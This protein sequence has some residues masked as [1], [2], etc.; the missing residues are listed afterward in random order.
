MKEYDFSINWSVKIKEAFVNSL[1][2]TSQK[3]GLTFLWINDENVRDVI[4]KLE[5][6]ELK[7]KFLLDTQATYNKEGDPY[8]R[9]C[10]AVKDVGGVVINDPDRARLATDKSVMHYELI[11]AGINTPYS[12]IVRNWEPNS[13]KLS[14]DEKQNL[15][16]LL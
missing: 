6:A 4:K 12:V 3:K 8:A 10:Y 5:S 11:N 16:F 15:G 1:K 13:F 7:I 14:D 9:V 2:E